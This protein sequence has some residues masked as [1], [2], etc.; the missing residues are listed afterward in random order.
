M[1]WNFYYHDYQ[2]LGT[3]INLKGTFTCLF[4]QNNYR[5]K[6]IQQIKI[7]MNDD[8]E[9]VGDYIFIEL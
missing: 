5:V 6:S 4:S 1:L 8:R 2:I 3:K 9:V 7:M